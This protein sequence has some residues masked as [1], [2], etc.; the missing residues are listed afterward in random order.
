MGKQDRRFEQDAQTLREEESTS[1][2]LPISMEQSLK[3]A[4][5]YVCVRAVRVGTKKFE[6][7]FTKNES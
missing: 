6:L 3:L 5:L 4:Q 7:R 2:V 1:N